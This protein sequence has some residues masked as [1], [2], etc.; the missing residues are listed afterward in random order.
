MDSSSHAPIPQ[1]VDMPLHRNAPLAPTQELAYRNKCIQLKKRLAEIELNN[2]ATRRKISQETQHVQKMRL[3]R[4][5]LLNHLKNIMESPPKKL[6]PEQREKLGALANGKGSLAELAGPGVTQDLPPSRPEGEGLLDDS[7][8]ESD[9]EE[10]EPQ[11]RPERRRRAN[12][13]L[14]ESMFL[15]TN[16]AAAS[17]APSQNQAPLSTSALQQDHAQQD[18]PL[19]DSTSNPQQAAQEQRN[20]G[21]DPYYGQSSPVTS[22]HHQAGAY[23]DNAADEVNGVR[24]G[25]MPR[26]ERPYPPFMQFTNH[27]QPQLEADN[28]PPSLIA[29]RISIEWDNLSDGNRQLWEDRYKEQMK[30][31]TAAMDQYKRAQRSNASGSGFTPSS[32]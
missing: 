27:M 3:L 22:T 14:R 17:P 8:E 15:S 31:Y 30:E 1:A 29:D 28:Y 2:D 6:T 16:N 13:S 32:S 7:S 19:P 10:P 24:H 23:T 12:N 26:P 20:D 21:S 9:E 18:S 25:P 5:I 4:S 11:E